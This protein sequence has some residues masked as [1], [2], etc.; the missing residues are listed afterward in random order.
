MRVPTLLKTAFPRPSDLV[1][2][3]VAPTAAIDPI[4]RARHV[5]FLVLHLA[6]A[7]AAFAAFPAYIVIRGSLSIGEALAFVLLSA[8]MM[9]AVF[10]SRTGRLED[11]QIASAFL[12]SLAAGTVA[13]TT[14]GL[15]SAA[16]IWL[17][18][19]PLEAMVS[20]SRRATIAAA[21]F[22]G[23]ALLGVVAAD[24]A[25]LSAAGAGIATS[26]WL[27]AALIGAAILHAVAL[28][29]WTMRLQAMGA[30]IARTGEAR[31]A[32]LAETMSDLVT[33]HVASGAIIYVSPAAEALIGTSREALA[34]QGL[35]ER[36]HVTDRLA[37][38]SALSKAYVDGEDAAVE[39][40][41]RRGDGPTSRIVW[42]EMRCRPFDD[43]ER[44]VIAI[45]R[46]ISDRKEQELTMEAAR[47]DAE[48]ANI[49]KGRFLATMSHELRTPLNAIIGFSEMLVSEGTMR[50]QPARRTEYARLIH[51][52]GL[53]LLGVVNGILDMSK[54]E[55]GNF[56]IEVEAFD[57]ADLVEN[58]RALMAMKYEAARIAL[59]ADVAEG[60]PELVA[61][62]R[63]CRQIYLN[64][65]SNAL[66]FT[67]AGGSVTIGARREGEQAVLYVTDTGIG[68]SSDDVQ[69]LGEPF[70]QAHSTYDRPFDGS[71]LGLSVV[72]G[73][74]AMHGGRMEIESRLGLG[75]TVSIRLPL[76]CEDAATR[77]AH[78]RPAKIASLTETAQLKGRAE[79]RGDAISVTEKKIA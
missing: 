55:N 28:G 32:L 5:R 38:L 48:R 19:P 74:A 31:Y 57:V 20:A 61:D 72:K 47:R 65:V 17:L 1:S 60:M 75:T 67:P 78:D 58:C 30:D 52:S 14:G 70:F 8:A 18:L 26:P 66:K 3:M 77:A 36:V 9:P 64:L 25:G 7:L 46:D 45:T 41:V 68:V 29:L 51:E 76:N 10:L 4:A 56:P 35:F 21:M 12:L 43:P 40:R 79:A 23:L 2:G 50:I 24:G 49:A 44:Q 69:R 11:A 39:F 37:Y 73:L 27:H 54:I 34:G 62:K 15:S 59:R 63:A 42:M 53:H 71:G 33:R 16:V 22:S 6:I 13:V